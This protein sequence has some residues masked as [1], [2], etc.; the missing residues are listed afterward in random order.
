MCFIGMVLVWILGAVVLNSL[1]SLIGAF[2]L[3]FKRKLLDRILF[4]LV[5]FAA[6]AL[7]GAA[8]LD[9]LPEAAELSDSSL[10]YA[11]VGFVVFLVLE[12]FVYWYHCH[13]GSCD[14]HSF[15]YLNL[16]G[17]ALHNLLDGAVIA[18]SFLVS[19]PLG[20]V[21]TLAI[22]LHEI[23]QEIGDFAVL[24]FGGVNPK[25]A[26]LFNFLTALTSILGAV[27][28]Y[29]LS[30]EVTNF[31]AFLVPFAAGSFIYIAATDLIPEL[32]KE[33]NVKKS[34][35][36]FLFLLIGLLLIAGSKSLLGSP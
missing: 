27:V 16:V 8:F 4:V 13:K 30:S 18:A 19:I 2:T 23:P 35:I 24:V 5:S 28:A 9:L 3:V 26:L 12:K 1:I 14:V 25:K 7:L 10:G 15:T 31:S 33:Q 17:D 6:G 34:A 20:L 11:L 21:T 22:V 29:F 36:Q 32:N